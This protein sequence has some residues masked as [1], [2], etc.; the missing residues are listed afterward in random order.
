MKI[1]VFLTEKWKDPVWSKVIAGVILAILGHIGGFVANVKIIEMYQKIFKIFINLS[2][3]I[4]WSIL[5]LII[6]G[7][8]VLFLILK[9]KK[10][11]RKKLVIQSSVISD[12]DGEKNELIINKESTVFFDDRFCDAFPGI[13]F[14]G[15]T[16]FTSKKEIQ[17]R[18]K[19]LLAH[20]LKFDKGA[21]EKIVLEPI[22]WFRGSCA[23]FIE[24]FAI[25]NRNKI[26]INNQELIIEK[27]AVYRGRSYFENYVYVQCLPD[28]PTGIYDYE[29]NFLETSFIEYGEYQETFGLFK[30][31]VISNLEYYDGSAVINGK[32]QKVIG[33]ELRTR[34]LLKYNFIIAAKFSPYNCYDFSKNSEEYFA[35]LLKNEI[36]F[37]NF[38]QWM[39]KFPKNTNDY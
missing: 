34:T 23:S 10:L 17:D 3:T 20:P 12:K 29:K 26:L 15:Y 22:W 27:I 16:W 13:N 8:C 31:K 32:L 37:D 25:L 35:K 7:M 30:N 39:R 6:I 11:N 18:L 38:V 33:A 9:K 28:K 19:I 4:G 1:K 24:N 14:G 36:Q 5:L 2:S 21:K